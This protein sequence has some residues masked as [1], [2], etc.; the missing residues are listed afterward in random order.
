MTFIIII[1]IIVI[2]LMITMQGVHFGSE[3]LNV[4]T[5]FEEIEEEVLVAVSDCVLIIILLGIIII[6]RTPHA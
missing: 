3:Q 4:P 1:I 2:T 6:L 5:V